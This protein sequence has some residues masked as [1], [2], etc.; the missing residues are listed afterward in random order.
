MDHGTTGPRDQNRI[1]ALIEFLEREIWST[2]PSKQLGTK[3]D[4]EVVE[5]LLGYG[6]EGV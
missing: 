4:E 6:P 3:L 1:K 5:E 2:V